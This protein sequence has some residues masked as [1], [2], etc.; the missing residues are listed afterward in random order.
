M[1]ELTAS[2]GEFLLGMGKE[3]HVDFESPMPG[4]TDEPLV[5]RQNVRFTANRSTFI[6]YWFELKFVEFEILLIDGR[7]KYT[8][9]P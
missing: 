6:G 4:L 5:V 2:V 9:L 7:Y 3:D 1:Q 8:V